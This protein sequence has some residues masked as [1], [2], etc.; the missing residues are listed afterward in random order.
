[1]RFDDMP[2]AAGVAGAR[3]V[4][5]AIGKTDSLEDEP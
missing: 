1:M 5:A 4:L 3:R 2:I